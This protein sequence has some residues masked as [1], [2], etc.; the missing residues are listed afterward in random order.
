[1]TGGMALFVLM[2]IVAVGAPYWGTSDPL[3]LNPI[4]R[5]L[6]PSTLHWFGTDMLGR[7][8]YSR[9]LYGSRVSLAVGMCVATL[10]MSIGLAIG[11]VSGYHRHVDAVVMRVMDGMMA[12]PAILLAIA[13]MAL[14]SG[15]VQNVIIAL[16]IPEIPRVGRVVRAVVLS[17][18]EQMYVEA[19]RAT[20]ASLPRILVRH[21]MPNTL[22]P[23]IVRAPAS[24]RP[25]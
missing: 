10:S 24:V 9:T 22:V 14:V 15:S 16:T 1:M 18:R 19:S 6:S 23:L 13:L 17:L 5:L 25:R 4:D 7:D 2:V 21:I 3:E 20:G 8:L 12:I 11:L